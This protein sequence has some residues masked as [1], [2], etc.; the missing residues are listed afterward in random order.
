MRDL[1]SQLNQMKSHFRSKQIYNCSAFPQGGNKLW[2]WVFEQNKEKPSLLADTQLAE[3]Q[4]SS[5]RITDQL[6]HPRHCNPPA[7]DPRWLWRWFGRKSARPDVYHLDGVV[8]RDCIGS[9]LLHFNRYSAL[10]NA[11]PDLVK[12]VGKPARQRPYKRFY[13]DKRIREERRGS[14]NRWLSIS[15]KGKL[16]PNI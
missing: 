11:Q 7:L 4:V 12:S 6:F 1:V 9:L 16:I 15:L 14:S 3:V 13:G 5:Q 2:A 10:I 8:L